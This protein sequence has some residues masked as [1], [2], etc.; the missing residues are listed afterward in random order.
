MADD[1]T[2]VAVILGATFQPEAT[3]DDKGGVD[4]E[5][6]DAVLTVESV[7]EGVPASEVTTESCCCCDAGMLTG[8]VAIVEDTGAESDGGLM[9]ESSSV[10]LKDGKEVSKV[11][12]LS[13]ELGPAS[14]VAAIEIDIV[15]VGAASKEAV[16]AVVCCCD[17]S[18]EEDVIIDNGGASE[19]G[20]QAEIDKDG[21]G[22]VAAARVAVVVVGDEAAVV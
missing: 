4:K 11:I 8:G 2:A 3:G 16:T 6:C 20:E 5:S 1:V 18:A 7:V 13:D 22:L 21:V 19:D 14:V 12:V 9:A 10:A 17:V 15:V